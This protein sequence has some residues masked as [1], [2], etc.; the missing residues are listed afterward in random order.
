MKFFSLN[1]LDQRVEIHVEKER[2]EEGTL[3]HPST[4]WK[5]GYMIFGCKGRCVK[6]SAKMFDK[7]LK[8]DRNMVASEYFAS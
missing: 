2:T 7:I 5:K 8:R 3:Q 1:I 6:I 4:Y